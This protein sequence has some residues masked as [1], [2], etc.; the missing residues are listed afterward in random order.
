MKISVYD[1]TICDDNLGNQIIMDA[2]NPVIDKYFRDAFIIRLQYLEKFGRAS[3][4]HIRESRYTFFGGTNALSSQMNR[5]SQM[6]F[7]LADAMR[8]NNVVLVGVGWWQYQKEPNLYTQYLLRKIL[9]R[10]VIH[11]VRDEYTKN[12]LQSIGVENVV[13]TSCPTVWGLDEEHCA[14][15]PLDKSRNVVCT[16]T[17]YNQNPVADAAFLRLMTER[18][19]RCYLWLQGAGDHDYFR[20]LGLLADAIELIPP[21][22]SAYDQVLRGG[23]IDYIGTRLHAGV[24]ALQHARRAL[25][26]GIDNRAIEI[27]KHIGLN[28]CDRK[29]IDAMARFCHGGEPTRL[30]I[31]AQEIQRWQQQ[32]AG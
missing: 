23:D 21:K 30:Y 17:D 13:N 18:Y 25:I 16:L 32:F 8:I 27:S 10:D 4:R 28:V 7:T 29:D 26:L 14:K 11:S 2:I 22:L 3:Q 6:G 24:R 15:I 5:Y 12:Y 31:P 19:E 20:T 9:H 1:T